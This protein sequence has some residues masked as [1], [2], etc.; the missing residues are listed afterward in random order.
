[1]LYTLL[2]KI[3]PAYIQDYYSGDYSLPRKSTNP[4]PHRQITALHY[5][6]CFELGICLEGKGVT[7]V[8]NRLYHFSEGDMIVMPPNVPHVS[9]AQSG[10]HT[11]WQ[12]ISLEPMRILRESGIAYTD[13]LQVMED[14][15]FRGVFHPWEHPRL[16]EIVLQFRDMELG[17][18]VH[19]QMACLFL[20]GQL[21][22]ECGRIGDI[23]RSYVEDSEG[24]HKVMPA[25]KYIRTHYADQEAMRQ[26]KI[27]QSCQM[28]IS[29]FR[30]VFKR[31]TGMSVRDFIIQTRLATAA[32]LLSRTN[33]SVMQVAME[34]GFGQISCFNRIFSREF[35]LTPSAFRKKARTQS[36]NA[37]R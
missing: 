6:R 16:A 11:V 32:H 28:S 23:D 24:T 8:D 36:A 34:S 9:V 31:E 4:I 15:G 3:F 14:G 30:A 25:V 13:E 21:L 27:A 2:D 35:G 18:G 33:E 22:M 20:S 10:V 5:H 19:T 17:Q 1:M 29:H 26:E 12:W 37:D 7:Y